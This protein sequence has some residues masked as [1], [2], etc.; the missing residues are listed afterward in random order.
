M[1]ESIFVYYTTNRCWHP[2]FLVI[3]VLNA[4]ISIRQ[5]ASIITH[6]FLRENGDDDHSWKIPTDYFFVRVDPSYT[7]GV[8]SRYLN[9]CRIGNAEETA[10]LV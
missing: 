9:K 8:P 1:L 5:L 10:N 2:I 4:G 6:D 7:V 3:H